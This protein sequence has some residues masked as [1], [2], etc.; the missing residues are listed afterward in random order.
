LAT[1]RRLLSSTLI[2]IKTTL[3][4]TF[5]FRWW[6]L[7][8]SLRTTKKEFLHQSKIQDFIE[9][10]FLW[11]SI[12]S[13]LRKATPSIWWNKLVIYLLLKS[14]LKRKNLRINITLIGSIILTSIFFATMHSTTY[15]VQFLQKSAD[16][17]EVKLIGQQGHINL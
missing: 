10:Q 4:F 7:I 6:L 17:S 13:R 1:T 11:L 15:Q 12:W 5:I 8:Y 16:S 9:S 2:L 3:Q 14:K